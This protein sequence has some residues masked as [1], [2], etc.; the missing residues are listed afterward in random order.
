V[1]TVVHELG[2]GLTCKRFGGEVHEIGGLLLYFSPGMY[3][4]VNDAWTFERRSH[5]LWVTFAGPWI[6][7]F[8]AS[9]AA[10]VWIATEPGT[11][12]HQLAFVTVLLAGGLAV[13]INLNPLI[14]LDGY[15]ALMDWL[16]VPNLRARSFE[17]LRARV[18]RAV[19]GR[20]TALPA[21]TPRER[22]IFLL[23]GSL[24][25]LYSS[26]LL[27]V[28][29]V[30]ATGVLTGRLGPWGWVVV[31]AAAWALA[32][33]K[34]RRA[35]RWM[36]DAAAGRTWATRR[37]AA[38]AA[39]VALLWLLALLVPWTVRVDGV[40]VVEPV[41][42]AWLRPAEE[43]RVARVLAGEGER[44]REGDTLAVLHD[45]AIEMAW[46]RAAA[47]VAALSAEAAA[48][49]AAADPARSR[50]SEL[51]LAAGRRHL[52]ELER[53]REGLVLLAPF[54][55]TLAT[56]RPG[57][58]VGARAAAGDSLLE[59]WRGGALRVRVALPERSAGEVAPGA[60]VAVKFPV[61]P[62][63]TWRTRVQAVSPST[64]E[65]GVEF[66]APL[67]ASAAS[68][69]QAPLRGGMVGRARVEVARTSVAGALGRALRRTLRTDWLL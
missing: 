68:G 42:R 16:E 66:V 33:R 7:L 21:V 55:G 56:P 49:R 34:L 3:C 38:A 46:T 69:D 39:A 31:A 19:L 28:V 54:A 61:R 52:G 62:R 15:F 9:L 64:R 59:L 45:P 65:G 10:V 22:R 30:W 12:V 50:A 13:L 57:E 23:Y 14:P 67:G 17:Y 40:A 60:A 48:T 37:T 6:E 35:G 47:A 43:G 36:L 58:L 27:L 29:A 5:R 32:G 26:G 1:V 63:W 25:V 4:N 20:R 24:A 41:E 11:L 44:V 8:V 53:R 18:G 2:H 51:R